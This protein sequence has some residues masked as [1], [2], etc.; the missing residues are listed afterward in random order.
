MSAA[1]PM[2]TTPSAGALAAGVIVAAV[3]GLAFGLAVYALWSYVR[4]RR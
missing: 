2:Y 1:G 3:I 4:Q